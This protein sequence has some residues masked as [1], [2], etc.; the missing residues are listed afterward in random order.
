MVAGRTP[1]DTLLGRFQTILGEHGISISPE[2][3]SVEDDTRQGDGSAQH[4]QPNGAS[5]PLPMH[6]SRRA[7][8]DE[9]PARPNAYLNA[10]GARNGTRTMRS[11]SEERPHADM[12]HLG[13]RGRVKQRSSSDNLTKH[14][15]RSV[16]ATGSIRISR[17]PSFS[18]GNGHVVSDEDTIYSG[19]TMSAQSLAEI[20]GQT[21]AGGQ[22]QP[23]N[24]LA[25]PSQ[26]E[27]LSR[28]DAFENKQDLIRTRR[29]L[30]KWSQLAYERRAWNGEKEAE[31]EA[32]YRKKLLPEVLNTWHGE[33]I[34]RLEDLYQQNEAIKRSQRFAVWEQ[35]VDVL[36]KRRLVDKAFT[37]WKQEALDQR[38]R[39]G[40]AVRH[41]RR[42]RAFN[43]WRS[44]TVLD[45]FKV[46][47]FVLWRFFKRWRDRSSWAEQVD[48]FAIQLRQRKLR[49]R[50]YWTW[51]YAVWS[52]AVTRKRDDKIL[53]Q[54]L[55]I[56]VDSTREVNRAVQDFRL[57]TLHHFARRQLQKW[58]SETE[59]RALL[60]VET[61]SSRTTTVAKR[62]ITKWSTLA[63]L[64]AKLRGASGATDT[65]VL[66]NSL[67][68]WQ[69][70]TADSCK[71]REFRKTHLLRHALR[72]WRLGHRY[73]FL[74]KGMDEDVI[75]EN[76]YKWKLATNAS[77]ALRSFESRLKQKCLAH[78]ANRALEQRATLEETAEFYGDT[79]R[80]VRLF[81]SLRRWLYVLHQH[82]NKDQQAYDFWS[83]RLLGSALDKWKAQHER[84]KHKTA[85]AGAA[86]FYILT[87]KS[88]KTWKEKTVE[89]QRIRRREAY[90]QVRRTV[91]MNVC[92]D[93]LYRMR[94]A[95][96]HI[97]AMDMTAQEHAEDKAMSSVVSTLNQWR[98]KT[99][100]ILTHEQQAEAMLLQRLQRLSFDGMAAR[101]EHLHYFNEAATSFH[102]AALE[103]EASNCFKKLDRRLFQT[104][105]QDQWAAALRERHWEKRVRT[106]L[107]YW[108]ERALASQYGRFKRSDV[109][110]GDQDEYDDDDES[111]AD[112]AAGL[113]TSRKQR[114]AGDESNLID[115]DTIYDLQAEAR[116]AII[117]GIN[118]S[119]PL[120]GYLRTP[121][122]RSAA[123][124][125]AR[126]R[127]V[128][129]ER[130]TPAAG[131]ASRQAPLEQ[132]ATAPPGLF[133]SRIPPNPKNSVTPFERKLRAQGY[134]QRFSQPK[135]PGRGN[136]AG[137]RMVE[138]RESRKVARFGD[139]EDIAEDGGS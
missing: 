54:T 15:N 36:R 95:V 94:D 64:Q 100:T 56:W 63:V 107:R 27:L 101:R 118:T 98:G 78:W 45:A 71:A 53:Q 19:A 8:F 92:R 40:T 67:E 38:Q 70:H 52:Q 128:A 119:T 72:G 7:S 134:S 22:Y 80:R 47:R 42:T 89:H 126:E 125:K 13:L 117:P 131:R 59:R 5:R 62:A 69:R 35:E 31:A 133:G 49:E 39:T 87:T 110:P 50:G 81:S 60:E 103:R 10:I 21:N 127:L 55:R 73:A 136:A 4:V 2:E 57:I 3:D 135:T 104:K 41:I 105:G 17:R 139:F 76:F 61:E 124:A 82:E 28:A 121:S 109:P 129:F 37:H 84:I 12:A 23:P 102:L 18:N 99:Q 34:Q 65:R 97:R 115:L 96:V 132:P 20:V 6:S 68:Q 66:R 32:Q 85:Q 137:S 74:K 111:P 14:R 79:Q 11:M 138:V 93:M 44:V 25:R 46:R 77:I 16:S 58:A 113:G 51:M 122:K 33:H 114:R 123:R 1:E 116:D 24:L 29:T 130:T 91:K 83:H 90:I 43:G 9:A 120:P 86:E 106:M 88:I 30:R 48:R 75:A 108:A 112:D 26:A